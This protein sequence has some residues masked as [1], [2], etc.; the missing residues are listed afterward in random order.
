MCGVVGFE[1][2]ERPKGL[3]TSR[4]ETKLYTPP[5]RPVRPSSVASVGRTKGRTVDNEL[6]SASAIVRGMKGSAKGVWKYNGRSSDQDG[7]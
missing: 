4:G 7:N 6:L 1:G 2:A 5:A 3:I